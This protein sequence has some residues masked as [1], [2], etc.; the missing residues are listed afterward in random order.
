MFKSPKNCHLI[1]FFYLCHN[2]E[3]KVSTLLKDLFS[4]CSFSPDMLAPPSGGPSQIS[5][6]NICPHEALKWGPTL[7][8]W[9]ESYPTARGGFRTSVTRVSVECNTHSTAEATFF[10][11]N[12]LESTTSPIWRKVEVRRHRGPF[13]SR[14]LWGEVCTRST[15]DWRGL[16]LSWKSR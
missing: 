6:S 9:A 16:E 15:F 8:Y 11:F 7:K 14:G 3:W 10:Y 2:F 13:W 1:S 12:L 4:N 5:H